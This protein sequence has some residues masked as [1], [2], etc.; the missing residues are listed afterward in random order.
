V[1]ESGQLKPKSRHLTLYLLSE[2]VKHPVDAVANPGRL[3]KHPLKSNA[4]I[5]G[6]LF[7]GQSRGKTPKWYE[8][9]DQY[10][11]PPLDPKLNQS[12]SGVLI[13]EVGGR[14]FAATFGQ[15][16]RYYLKPDS[17]EP[18]FGLKVTLNAVNAD[19]LRSVDL[20]TIEELTLS[21][22]RQV[23]RASP[24]ETFGLDVSRDLLRAVTGEPKDPVLRH[25]S[26]EQI[27]SSC[28]HG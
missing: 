8:F 3:K 23:S 7:V 5:R 6:D 1:V 9:V 2:T 11:R 27:P 24:L 4:G 15:A 21:T 10:V 20:R 16:G 14:A 25:E 17:W 18:D 13:L 19:Q 22:R 28:R 12:V 26:R